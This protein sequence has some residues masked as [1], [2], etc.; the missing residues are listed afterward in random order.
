MLETETRPKEASYPHEAM[1]CLNQHELIRKYRC[2]SC[3]GVAMCSCDEEFGRRFLSHQLRQGSVLHTR[4]R[5][6]VTLGFKPKVCA[7]CRGLPAVPAPAGETHGRTSKIKRYYWREIFFETTRRVATWEEA[8]PG[9]TPEVRSAARDE[10]ERAVL[11]ETRAV[12]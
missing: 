8:H 1:Q 5:V 11:D 4:E 6:P 9:T 2:D 3:G 12:H 7:E 10:I